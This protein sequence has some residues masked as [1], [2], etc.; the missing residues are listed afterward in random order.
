MSA[1][2]ETQPEQLNALA[3]QQAA[4]LAFGRRSNARPELSVLMQDAVALVSEVLGADFSGVDRVIGGKLVRKVVPRNE[5]GSAADPVT[6]ESSLAA[7]DSIAGFALSEAD[8]V[9]AAN[10]GSDKRFTDLFLRKLGVVGALCVPL[11]VGNKPFGAL[12]IYSE[13]EREFTKDDAQFAET[14]AQLLTSSV[15]RIQA[16]EA[17]QQQR[18]FSSTILETVDALVFTLD[19]RCHLLSMNRACRQVTGF[20]LEEV[21]GKAFCSM[22]AVPEEVT[23]LEGVFRGAV[24]ERSSQEF[25]SHLLTK[26]GNRRHIC[27]SLKPISGNSGELESIAL[28]GIDRTA[29]HH[30]LKEL[31]QVKAVAE[32]ANRALT[33]LRRSLAEGDHASGRQTEPADQPFQKVAGKTGREK[34][35]SPRRNFQYRQA[36]A[37]M[38]GDAMP[39]R[40]KFFTVVCEDISAG[41]LSFYLENPPE[42]EDL[43]VALG[44]PPAIS[45]FR[46]KVVRVMDRELNGQPVHLVGCRFTGRVHL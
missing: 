21:K 36:I 35:S 41:G 3:R 33:E 37:P 14:I 9:V 7:E 34:R 5:Q 31:E 19:A 39:S 42:F 18:A 30:A 29:E 6:H 24:K 17:L 38:Y 2:V 26:D 45:F 32:E 25:E 44:Q 15:G 16:E 27:W 4:L 12:E 10:V 46:A 22:L 20:S 13:K 23:R 43:V 11:H 28:T 1:N 40:K 8:S